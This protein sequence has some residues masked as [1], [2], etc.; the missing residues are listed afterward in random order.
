MILKLSIDTQTTDSSGKKL[1]SVGP[2]SE[3]EDIHSTNHL[4][5]SQPKSTVVTVVPHS[6]TP[7]G[8]GNVKEA[9]NK[10]QRNLKSGHLVNDIQRSP[11]A[12]TRSSPELTDTYKY[13]P[14]QGTRNKAPD[15]ENTPPET[16][17][18]S[19]SYHR[20]RRKNVEPEPLNRISNPPHQSFE[21]PIES[22]IDSSYHREDMH[23][24]EQDL[25]NMMA[26]SGF[27]GFNG[28]VHMPMNLASGNLPFPI[29]PS[30]LSSLGYTQR[31]L[32]GMVPANMSFDPAFPGMQFP[33]GLVSPQ[34]T[35]YFS[36]VGMPSN[37][38]DLVDPITENLGSAEMNSGDEFWRDP[39]RGNSEIVPQDDK[40]QPSSTNGMNYV[41]PPRRVGGSGGLVRSQQKYNKEK[42]DRLRDNNNSHSDHP[43]FQENDERTTSS[44]FSSSAHGNSLRSKTSSESSWEESSMVVSRPTKEKRGKKTVV[45]TESEDDDQEWVPPTN[46]GS[47]LIDKSSESQSAG[48]V[49]V[50]RPH[51]SGIEPAQSS[52]SGSVIP[53]GPMIIGSNPRQRIMDNSGV[54]QPLTFYP[55]GPPVPFLTMLPFN[56]VPSENGSSDA[57]TSHLGVDESLDN[58]E[59]GLDQS[60]EFSSRGGNPGEIP[61]EPKSDILNSD[62]ASHWQN[63]QFGRFCQSPLHHGPTVYPSPVMVPPVYLQGRVPWDGPGRPV[64]NMNLVTQLMNYGP[65]LVSVAPIQPVP[66]RP[67]N[68]YQHYV[69]DM[70]RYRSGTGTY[71]PN[72]VSN[73]F[74][75]L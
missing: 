34:L 25:V 30:F 43:Q 19:N 4:S 32:A 39:D 23:Q 70:P 75:S 73:F 14:F 1:E 48:T 64:P 47:E 40:P 29:S 71:L 36:G 50:P 65:R 57:S 61:D 7:K 51:V 56:Y 13:V 54:T 5:E 53:M 27:H 2:E 31:N 11:F 38:G 52:G 44:R 62:F 58:G 67:P 37:S 24:E 55:T 33:H 72:P 66:N 22:N 21:T 16:H 49:H 26:Y 28:Q 12:R 41:P 35:H 63:L 68:V 8:Y 3:F 10:G 15:T 20:N 74:F 17:T 42:R 6:Q 60:D 18:G 46:L 9:V 69:E 45:P 59:I